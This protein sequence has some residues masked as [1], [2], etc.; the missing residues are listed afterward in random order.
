MT[1]D[2]EFCY[3][4]IGGAAK[5]GT[6]SLFQY[7]SDHPEICG[8]ITKETGFFLDDDYPFPNPRNIT[9]KDGIDEFNKYFVDCHNQIYRLEA[10]PTYLYSTGT[11]S[12]I[13]NYYSNVKWI[14]IL[15]EPISRLVS[16]YRFIKQI[17]KLDKDTS[18]REYV[19]HQFEFGEW[20]G[21][22]CLITG[23]YS[24]YLPYFYELYPREDILVINFTE[25]NQRPFQVLKR[26]AHNLGTQV[27]FYENYN[28]RVHNPTINIKNRKLHQ[29]YNKV[30]R[31]FS[32]RNFPKNPGIRK[33]IKVN[34]KMV[35]YFYLRL[36]RAENEAVEIPQDLLTR[37]EEYYLPEKEVLPH[38]LSIKNFDWDFGFH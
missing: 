20:R 5:S 17:G 8:A 6:T 29:I 34:R 22:R 32:H 2:Q 13:R 1:V 7:M 25:L 16:C 26:I 33:L 10:T 27:S 35:D 24:T 11:P 14:F 37:L 15:R 36:N 23:R 21:S 19:E 4:F 3:I 31:R 18:F 9:Y 38:I 28:F 30:G 12:R